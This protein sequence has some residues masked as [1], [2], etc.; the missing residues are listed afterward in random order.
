MGEV[1]RAAL[2]FF[3]VQAQLISQRGEWTSSRQARTMIVGAVGAM[4]AGEEL[5]H[6]AW[7]ASSGGF[8][9]QR[10]IA[11]VSEVINGDNGD[12]IPIGPM[13]YVL[14]DYMASGIIATTHY[15]TYSALTASE[16]YKR[17]N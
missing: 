3:Q 12:V 7:G 5:S 8:T 4:D 11:T 6:L 13:S 10:T 15:G 2:R 9:H 14:V 17:F 16:Q 1:M